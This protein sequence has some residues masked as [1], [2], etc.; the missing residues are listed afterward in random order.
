M[1]LGSRKLFV[2]KT[3]AEM[4]C[5]AEQKAP[6]SMVLLNAFMFEDRFL[7]TQ[8][9]EALGV[10]EGSPTSGHPQ[11]RRGLGKV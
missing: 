5:A 10:A 2:W 7:Q 6:F 9:T 4:P 3:A 1:S 8:K 11:S